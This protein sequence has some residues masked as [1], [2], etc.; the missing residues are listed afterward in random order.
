MNSTYNR[1]HEESITTWK[2]QRLELVLEYSQSSVLPAPLGIFED[3]FLLCSSRSARRSAAYSGFFAAEGDFLGNMDR[4]QNLKGGQSSQDWFQW[5]SSMSFRNQWWVLRG[6]Q[7][8]FPPGISSDKPPS[9]KYTQKTCDIRLQRCICA[10]CQSEVLRKSADAMGE[11]LETWV[12]R[13]RAGEKKRR[14][15]LNTDSEDAAA[16]SVFAVTSIQQHMEK[17]SSIYVSPS[18]LSCKLLSFYVSFSV[19]L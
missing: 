18:V 6:W 10:T 13:N 7:G 16:A 19:D 17:V 1:V 9:C 4:K 5:L 8:Y 15:A 3:L 12:R 14:T 11:A 2:F